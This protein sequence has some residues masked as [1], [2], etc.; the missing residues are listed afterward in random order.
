MVRDRLL[1]AAWR[2]GLAEP[3]ADATRFGFGRIVPA[4]GTDQDPAGL[5]CAV[6]GA[7]ARQVAVEL[8][9]AT[10]NL[11]L[12]YARRTWS[13][14]VTRQRARGTGARDTLDLAAGLDPDAQCVFFERLTTEGHNLHPCGRTRLGWDLADVLRHDLESP[15]TS[16]GLVAVR[17]DLHLGDDF[18]E[19][20]AT[21]Y[22]ELAHRLNRTRYAV[23][24][25]HAWQ[26][27]RLLPTRYADLL[28][29]GALVP[30]DGA[31]LPA[32]PTAALRTL[33]LPP[34]R[35]GERR[36][37]KLSLD[38]Q[39]TSTRRS[40]SVASTRN[41]PTISALL[42]DLLDADPD[43]ARVVLFDELAG[44]AVAAGGDRER[45]LAAILRTGL[46]GRLRPGEVAIPGT[47]LYSTSPLTGMTVLAELVD[48]Y[49]ATRGV[50]Q[51]ASAARGF[52]DG[53]ARLLLPAALRLATCHGIGLEAHLQNCV[54]TFIG[55]VPHR[56][57]LRDF[58]GLRVHQPRLGRP[59][60][61]WP[62]SVIGAADVTTMLAKLG[63]TSL[64]AHLGEVVL[65]L[66]VSH[67]LDEAVAW[68]V[69][70]AVIDEVYAG[71]RG[72]PHDAAAAADHA[73]LT[74]PTMPHKALLR[75]RLD[76]AGGDRYVPVDNPLSRT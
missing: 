2:E 35:R 69:V 44:S 18:G 11:A 76:P 65:G 72:G 58:A 39:V 52:L 23:T 67:G 12:A 63:Y 21:A 45:D 71:L 9:D 70:R 22:P 42:R 49:A 26:L 48:R 34:D 56:L 50:R 8:A 31:R 3:P 15:G 59:L 19:T 5:A 60:R 25:A 14:A 40:I 46:S 6:L 10:A 38:I 37:L 68:S 74:A 17:R 32:V 55:G 53:Y 73:F 47:A 41:G 13:D 29:D 7:D 4:G 54:P 24:P 64:Q 43:G 33:L 20:L 30:I 61:L 28:A 16:L 27:D 62:G 75:M 51:R 66:V 1:A 36:Y 57:A